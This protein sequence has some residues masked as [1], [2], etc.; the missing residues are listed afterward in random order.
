VP[1]PAARVGSVEQVKD[2]LGIGDKSARELASTDASLVKI[3]YF[4]E[5]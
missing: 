1:E 2:A 5:S 3:G 4:K